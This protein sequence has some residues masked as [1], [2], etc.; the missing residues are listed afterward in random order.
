MTN[1]NDNTKNIKLRNES[2]KPNGGVSVFVDEQTEARGIDGLMLPKIDEYAAFAI[3]EIINASHLFVVAGQE[4]ICL[5]DTIAG[6][7]KKR[8][9]PR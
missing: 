8:L 3:P 7:A 4:C 5:T 2:T 9:K 1:K 6:K